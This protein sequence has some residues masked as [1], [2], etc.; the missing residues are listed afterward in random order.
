MPSGLASHEFFQT[1]WHRLQPV[2]L[3]GQVPDLPSS[4]SAPQ[5]GRFPTCPPHRAM[6]TPEESPHA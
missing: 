1:K 2:V 6:P 3:V 5:W 4:E